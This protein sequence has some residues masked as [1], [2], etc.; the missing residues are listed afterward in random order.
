MIKP[1]M[2]D[3]NHETYMRHVHESFGLAEVLG[4]TKW[5]SNNGSQERV[6]RSRAHKEDKEM[7]R[8]GK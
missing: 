6:A 8:E 5:K 3:C 4:L 7:E 2:H 1:A